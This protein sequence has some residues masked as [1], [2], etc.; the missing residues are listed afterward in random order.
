M[1]E[2]FKYLA[3]VVEKE[4][5][6]GG[7]AGANLCVIHKGET[8]YRRS[9]GKSD[10]ER[11]IPMTEDKMFRLFSMSK[12]ITA[13]AAMI[14]I[15]RGLLDTRHLL[16]WY[17]PTFADPKVLDENGERPASRDITIGDLLNMTSGIP[18]PDWTPAGQKMGALWGG[19][20][21][22]YLKG[23]K[24]FNT[25]DFAME[26]GKCPLV[27]DPGEKWM[28]GASADIMGA[29]VEA[30]TGMKF[31]EFLQKEIFEPL[32]MNDTGFWIPQEKYNRLAQCYEYSDNGIKPFTHFHLCLT[33]YKEPPAFESGGAGLI[34][35]MDDYA[36]FA[37]MLMNHGELNGKRVLG[38][39]TVEY[40]RRSSLTP[41]QTE[42][43]NWD[44]TIGHS[45]GNFMRVLKDPAR[46]G[47]IQSEGSF[48]WD[49][50]MG[51]Y[52][53]LDPVKE[54]SVLY[55]IQQAGAGTTDAVIR[56]Q[57]IAFGAL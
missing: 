9:F 19:Q 25:Y 34:S 47:L 8:V 27:F 14:L 11:D 18:Y 57:N 40:M 54:A 50:W 15:E 2:N 49:G 28:Y 5:A 51:C 42:S 7:I 4:I 45:Y 43:L 39:N 22:N 17:I 16:K 12:P 20:S 44:S 52:F 23:E 24:L 56:L 46:A 30:V 48:G 35:T 37:K 13:C 38:A 36:K 10:M 3:P 55:F 32:E 41:K 21:E 6:N 1:Y 29:V 26:M 33:D 53:S 31:G